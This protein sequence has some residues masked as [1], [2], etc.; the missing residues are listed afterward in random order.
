MTEMSERFE[1]GRTVRRT[2][3]LVHGFTLY[4]WG[5]ESARYYVPAGA[6]IEWCGDTISSDEP[7]EPI[8]YLVYMPEYMPLQRPLREFNIAWDDEQ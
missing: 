7:G 2:G 5:A 4:Q 1:H 3:T 6:R 8:N